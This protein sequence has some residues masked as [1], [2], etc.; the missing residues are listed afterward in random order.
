MP[1]SL[2]PINILAIGYADDTPADSNRH[3]NTRIP[4][5]ELV[6]YC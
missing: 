6:T 4:V 3:A 2:E 5:E 1:E